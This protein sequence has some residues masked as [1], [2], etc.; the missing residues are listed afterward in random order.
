MDCLLRF[1]NKWVNPVSGSFGNY[2]V[3]LEMIL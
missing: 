3:Y 2:D 1:L